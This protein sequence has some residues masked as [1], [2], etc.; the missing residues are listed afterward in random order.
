MLQMCKQR[1]AEAVLHDMLL[2]LAQQL[3]AHCCTHAFALS[4]TLA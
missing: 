4:L 2:S 3:E 1:V